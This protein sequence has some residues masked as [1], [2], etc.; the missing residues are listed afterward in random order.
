MS[1]FTVYVPINSGLR[2]ARDEGSKY[3]R[4]LCEWYTQ[5]ESRPIRYQEKEARGEDIPKII[6]GSAQSTRV[7]GITGEDILLNF[8][9][10]CE[11]IKEMDRFNCR[12]E[13]NQYEA[14]ERTGIIKLKQ[15]ELKE[16]QAYPDSLFGVPALCMIGKGGREAVKWSIQSDCQPYELREILERKQRENRSGIKIAVDLRYAAVAKNLVNVA[17]NGMERNGQPK[18][19]IK[20]RILDGKVDVTAA[21][22]PTIDYAFDIVLSGKT[23]RENGLGIYAKLFESDGVIVG[24]RKASELNWNLSHLK[25]NWGMK[26]LE[27][28]AK[29]DDPVTYKALKSLKER[30]SDGG[31][32]GR[33]H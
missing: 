29:S 32:S 11:E 5:R 31:C 3:I 33:S 10:G 8:Y 14:E 7:V 22:D 23:C 9:S 25:A 12:F 15:L 2:I 26:M 18:T 27:A 19:D 24:N 4:E 17:I 1:V 21:I 20:W 16:K 6:R 28:I 13:T 30:I